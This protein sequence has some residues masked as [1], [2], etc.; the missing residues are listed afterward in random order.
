MAQ[1]LFKKYFWEPIRAG[2]K[3]TTLRRW[4]SPRVKTGGR[5]FAPGVGWLRVDRVEPVELNVLKDDDARGD[6]FA[7]MAEMRAALAEIYPD[8]VGDGK[9]WFRVE[10]SCE[11][12]DA[13]EASN[14]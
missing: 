9:Q 12:T 7:S 13:S 6:G 10:F 2:T 14:G 4:T 1:L 5:A 3:R 11:P 8:A